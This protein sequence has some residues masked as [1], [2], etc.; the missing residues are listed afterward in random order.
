MNAFMNVQLK[1]NLRIILFNN[2]GGEIFA[3]LPGLTLDERS[4]K[5]VT[6]RTSG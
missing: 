3:A 1:Q 6:R 4:R 5:F 2:S